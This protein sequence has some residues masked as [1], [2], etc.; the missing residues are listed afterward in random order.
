MNENQTVS[1]D[2]NGNPIVITP[3]VSQPLDINMLINEFNN[4][5]E[6][7]ATVTARLSAINALPNL[8]PAIAAKIQAHP[9]LVTALKVSSVSLS[10]AQ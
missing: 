3:Q 9:T 8:A 7:L 2:E 10:Q 6:Q 1:V 4:L 5:T